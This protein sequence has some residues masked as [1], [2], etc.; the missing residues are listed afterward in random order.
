MLISQSAVWNETTI[1]LLLQLRN[2]SV[3]LTQSYLWIW[4]YAVMCS[5]CFP[6]EMVKQRKISTQILLHLVS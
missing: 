4:F 2:G 6:Q 3:A 5:K 1:D